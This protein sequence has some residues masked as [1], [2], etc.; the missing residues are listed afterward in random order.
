MRGVTSLL[1]TSLAGTLLFGQVPRPPARKPAASPKAATAPKPAASSDEKFPIES[2]HI[3]GSRLYP[4]A[5]ILALAGLKV[6]E[7][8]SKA[9]FDAVQRK[10][11][12]HG[13]FSGVS[14]RYA[15]AAS[16]QGYDVLFEVTDT[17]QMLPMKFDR[18]PVEEK[19]IRQK[20]A[21]V[22]PLFREKIPGTDQV[23][24]RYRAAVE[25]IVG[26]KV[27]SKVT[28]DDPNDLYILFY[29]AGAP[30]VVAQVQFLGNKSVP[31]FQLHDAMQ[32][33]AVG[34][35]YR[36]RLFRELLENQ[37]RPLYEE[38]GRLRVQ[39]TKVEIAPAANVKGLKVTVT[40]SEGPSY[41]F[42]EA[43]VKGAGNYGD[44]LLKTAGLKEGE[45]ANM[46]V[47]ADAKDRVQAGLK[48]SGHMNASVKVAR[49]LDDEKKLANIVFDVEPG[50][51]YTFGKL[52]L[53]NMD[54]HGEHEIRR[55]WNMKPGAPFNGEYPDY[56]L[57]RLKEDQIF[58][59][60]RD[61][62][63]DLVPDHQSRTVDVTLVFNPP[64]KGHEAESSDSQGGVDPVTGRPRG[65][66]RGRRR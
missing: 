41:S 64:K 54:I 66:G 58:E 46:K 45:V 47:V 40:L 23:M 44:E 52:F 5:S 59:N 18:L 42:G 26:S 53:Q 37:I 24:E 65:G 2:I 29:P 1:L 10:L 49:Q 4:E 57:G 14:Y 28:S 20:L 25:Q 15:P 61:T 48:K 38:R 63:A 8:V 19:I 16:N 43:A 9:N 12:E 51:Q 22:D 56:F 32:G 13:A 30:P 36:E 6:G 39:F 31:E 27:Q 55:L 62:R 11:S 60:L 33:V 50:P 3:K 21:A 35:E 34:N 7:H 17:E